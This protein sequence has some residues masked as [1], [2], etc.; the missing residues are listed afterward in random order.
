MNLETTADPK[1]QN[2]ARIGRLCAGVVLVACTTVVGAQDKELK[3]VA[4]TRTSA[5][6]GQEMFELLCRHCGWVRQRG[7]PPEAQMSEDQS[8]SIVSAKI[9][10][11][12]SSKLHLGA[13][14]FERGER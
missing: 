1:Q 8:E 13:P 2:M 14:A 6:S 9:W 12:N 7:E 10:G 11:Q 3:H 4:A 5:A